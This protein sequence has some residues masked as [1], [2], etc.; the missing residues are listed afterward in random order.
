MENDQI[1]IKDEDLKEEDFSQED[2]DNEDFDWKAE[3]QKLK[4]IAKRRATQLSKAKERLA[5]PPKLEPKPQDKNLQPDN[6]LL[7]KTNEA[8][9]RLE[10]ATLKFAGITDSHQEEVYTKWKE[11]TGRDADAIL[12]NEIFKKE[13]EKANADFANSQASKGIKG[14]GGT[15]KAKLSADYYIAEN[16]PP[17]LED[18]GGDHKELRRISREILSRK[19]TTGKKFYNE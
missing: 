8:L 17:T 5:N 13:L 12:G 18:V 4:G 6:E 10:K 15:S 19:S 1:E 9:E 3:A 16:R 11:A 2:L 14:G 7:K